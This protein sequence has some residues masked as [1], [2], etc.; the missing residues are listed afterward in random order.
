MGIKYE[1]QITDSLATQIA[2]SIRDAILEGRL[3]VDERLPTEEELAQ[4]FGVSRPTIREA[5][6]RLAAQN[7][8]RSRRGPSGGTF[9]NRPSEEESR[10][11]LANTVALMVSMG[12]FSLD[13][14]TEAR[15]EMESIC[16]RLAAEHRQ[17]SQLAAMAAELEIQK[18]MDIT[19]VD[20]CASD[21]RFHRALVNATQNPVLRFVMVSVIEALQPIANMVVYRFR[22]RELI[23]SQHQR[24]YEAV[25]ARDPDAAETV[26]VEQMSYLGEKYAEA[27]EWRRRRDET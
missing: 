11:F 26:F 25:R 1:L 14:I 7:L 6:K 12:A 20:F 5:L 10:S 15:R 16:C 13:E 19:D 21:V 17:E 4:K 18:N 8:V 3:K 24:L 27:Q 23:V 2:K 22:E 9:V